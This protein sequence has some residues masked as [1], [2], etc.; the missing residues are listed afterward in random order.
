MQGL[1]SIEKQF[2][3]DRSIKNP[4]LGSSILSRTILP[5]LFVYQLSTA[6]VLAV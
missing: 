5:P 2:R 3:H 4:S 1:G 6:S